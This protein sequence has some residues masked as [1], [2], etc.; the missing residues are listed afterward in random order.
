MKKERR[1]EEDARASRPTPRTEDD[2][3]V[4]EKGSGLKRFRKLSLYCSVKSEF[5]DFMKASWLSSRGS[6]LWFSVHIFT[7]LNLSRNARVFE[8][9]RWASDS[10]SNPSATETIIC[11]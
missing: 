9:H 10:D 5:K 2:G 7:S 1:P 6:G 4:K 11:S 3:R 8:D